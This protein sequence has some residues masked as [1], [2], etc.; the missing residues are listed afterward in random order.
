MKQELSFQTLCLSSL[1]KVFADQS[2]ADAPFHRASAL[3]GETFAF[4]I[5][6]TANQMLKQVRVHVESS[7]SAPVTVRSIGLSPSEMCCYPDHDDNV[8]RTTPGLYPDPLYPL[9]D[10]SVTVMAGQWRSVWVDIELIGS[11]NPGQY[12]VKLRFES[13]EGEHLGEETFELEIIAAE[14][15]KPRLIH[16]EWFHTDCLATYYKVDIFSEE[17]WQLIEKYIDTAVK[18]GMNMI[19]TP[20]FTPPL[21]TEIGGERPTVQLVDVEVTGEGDRYAFGFTKLKRW[22]ELCLSKGAAYIEFSH[23]FTQWGAKHA[24]KIIA[25][26]NG[27]ACRIFGWDTDASGDAYRNFLKQFLPEL[28]LVIKQL[29]IEERSYFHIS[30]EPTTDH[31]ESYLHASNIIHEHLSE[32]PIIDALSEIAFY[33][34]GIV[35]RP[36]P[37]NNH[38]E[39]FLQAQVPDLWTYYCCVQYKHVSNRFFNMPSARNRVLGLQLYKF[40]IRGF[41]HWGYNFWYSQCSIKKLNP[42]LVT[43]ALHAFPSGDSFLVYPGEDGPVESIRLEVLYEAQQDLRALE[44]LEQFIGKERTIALLEEGLEQPLT[45]SEY[46]HS[47]E[48]MLSIR[49]KI[50]RAIAE[51]AVK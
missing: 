11:I 48:W 3:L 24:P 35:K 51:H 47:K 28:K 9:E 14:L 42:F 31:L 44:L 2:P 8:L 12:P 33:E 39:D 26:V 30:D 50:N 7:L 5:A 41:L 6:Y 23:L 27:E 40:D 20:L 16:T 37:G 13:K 43:D 25:N 18:H 29:G 45:F 15:P 19:L 32:Y 22:V 4:Q 46:P 10:G 1:S 36:I 34:K 21:D 49:E 38:I 17:H